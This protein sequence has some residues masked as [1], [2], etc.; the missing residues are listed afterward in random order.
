MAYSLKTP[1]NPKKNF[2]VYVK[3]VGGDHK[4]MFKNPK[5][6]LKLHKS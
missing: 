2:F 1:E 4:Q 3:E 6:I 5:K